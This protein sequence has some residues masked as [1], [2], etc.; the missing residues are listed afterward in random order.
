M[1]D[2]GALFS[3]LLCRDTVVE[4][5]MTHI[6]PMTI[7]D[8]ERCSSLSSETRR[9]SWEALEHE[10]YP[11]DKF[12]EELQLYAG[13]SLKAIMEKSDR[14]VL[15]A[16]DGDDLHGLLICKADA[17]TGIGDIG[18]LCVDK[19]RRGEGIARA[20]IEAAS[21]EASRR[22]CHKLIAYTMRALPDANAM[23]RKCGFEM[24]GDMRGHWMK[25]DFVQYGRHL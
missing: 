17:S 12:E 18:W 19:R 21:A 24:E 20:L 22:G 1:V 13:E 15:V 6:R 7:E 5:V 25:I 3:N 4:A 14:F 16:E 11:R 2:E 23:Y 10:F 8:L 9:D